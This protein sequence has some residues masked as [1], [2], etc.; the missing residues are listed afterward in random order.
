MSNNNVEP[1]YYEHKRYAPVPDFNEVSPLDT[2]GLIDA[3]EQR[4]R[5]RAVKIAHM[6][7]IEEKLKKCTL[8][9]GFHSF[10]HHCTHLIEEYNQTKDEI[11]GWKENKRLNDNVPLVNEHFDL[12][13]GQ[14]GGGNNKGN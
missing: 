10:Q 11:L 9:H 2:C 13:M 5:E 12:Q 7:Y 8:Y 14:R 3:L 1:Q 4:K 6:R